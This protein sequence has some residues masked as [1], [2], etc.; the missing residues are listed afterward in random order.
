[1]EQIRQSQWR[2][3]KDETG[4][5]TDI[6][7]NRTEAYNIKQHTDPD[8]CT[9]LWWGVSYCTGHQEQLCLFNH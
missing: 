3:D 6:Q 4:N 9:D 5:K 2:Q 7:Q 8:N 1:M